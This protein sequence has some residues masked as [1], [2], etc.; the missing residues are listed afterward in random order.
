[1]GA[2]REIVAEAAQASPPFQKPVSLEER[3]RRHFERATVFWW[4]V[5]SVVY[6]TGSYFTAQRPL[7]Y[8]EL[9]TYYLSPM[10]LSKLWRALLAGVD[11][12]PPTFYLLSAAAQKLAATAEVGLRIPSMVGMWLM[13]L[14]MFRYVRKRAS[15]L[16]AWLAVIFVWSTGVLYYATEARPY[17]LV[18]GSC[19]W[20]LVAWSEAAEPKRPR[21][22]VPLLGIALAAA[23]LSHAYAVLI[24]IPLG[25]G[26]LTRSLRQRRLDWPVWAALAGPLSVFVIY[27]PI[28]RAVHGLLQYSWSKPVWGR[29]PESYAMYFQPVW[30]PLLAML[31]LAGSFFLFTSQQGRKA[32]GLVHSG[33]SAQPLP[34]HEAVAL[35]TLALLPV[36]G[37]ILG[38]LF[39]GIFTGRYAIE[40]MVAFGIL[41][42][43]LCDRAMNGAALAGLCLCLVP[44][45]WGTVNLLY[46]MGQS[47]DPPASSQSRE[48]RVLTERHDLLPQIERSDLPVVISS[49]NLFLEFDHYASP[50]LA[51]RLHLLLDVEAAVRHAQVDLFDRGFPLMARWF[52]LRG[53]LDKYSEFVA[54]HPHF[55]VYGPWDNDIAHDWLVYRLLSDHA[56]L[57]ALGRTD[58]KKNV[59]PWS[60]MQGGWQY[61]YLFDVT[62]A[63]PPR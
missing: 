40:A 19:A 4:I 51:S 22:C 53:E 61:L 17:G 35:T 31:F 5:F 43:I 23:G 27:V 42:G 2:S 50:G 46:L 57:A 26:E 25:I 39:T 7:W 37:T 38:R 34:L 8:D 20:A 1:M 9:F 47:A 24:W 44:V 6:F 11:Q 32:P 54:K 28:Q 10:P 55:L 30:L 18:L 33:V 48:A 21:W 41:F 56:T 63:L 13:F 12:N 16:Y 3:L 52:P 62:T 60:P 49:G 29:I 58:L 15:P 45:G 59:P 36:F 14:A